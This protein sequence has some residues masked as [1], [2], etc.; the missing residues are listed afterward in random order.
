MATLWGKARA[1]PRRG[2][3]PLSGEGI[4]TLTALTDWRHFGPRVAEQSGN[5]APFSGDFARVPYS[6][7]RLAAF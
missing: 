4:C 2:L 7:R 6:D 3:R 5:E 1:E